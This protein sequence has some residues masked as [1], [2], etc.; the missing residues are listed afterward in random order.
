MSLFSSSFIL[1]AFSSIAFA[2]ESSTPGGG[3]TNSFT[4]A[5]ANG[6]TMVGATELGDKVR[7]ILYRSF[8]SSNH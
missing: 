7:Y 3:S 6:F 8:I 5:F 2:I 4:S 1:L